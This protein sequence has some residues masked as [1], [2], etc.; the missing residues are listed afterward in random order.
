MGPDRLVS[1]KVAGS[2]CLAREYGRAGFFGVLTPQGN[3]VAEAELRVLLPPGTVLLSARLVSSSAAL[4]QRLTDYAER[5]DAS[6]DQFGRLAFDAVGFACTG[7]SYS[8]DVES[9]RR[10]IGEIGARRGYPLITAA[11]ATEAAVNTLGI[12]SIAL[13]SPYPAWLTEACRAHWER[14]GLEVT[15][16]LQL[17]T[18]SAEDHGIYGLTSARVLEA[19]AGFQTRGAAGILLAGTGMAS[20]RVILQLEETRSLPV[21]SSNLCLAWALARV[22]GA[23]TRGPESRLYGGWAERLAVA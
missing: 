22:S 20:L 19:L 16:T 9:D 14:R 17:P 18:G 6:L 21:L 13:V 12:G 23:A 1:P 15:A 11:A 10:R 4:S 2:A 3:P 8:S 7:S 5:L